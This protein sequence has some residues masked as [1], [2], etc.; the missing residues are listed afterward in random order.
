MGAKGGQEADVTVP[1]EQDSQVVVDAEGPEAGQVTLQ[2]VRPQ[3]WITR[4]CIEPAQGGAQQLTARRAKL[5]SATEETRRSNDPH[6]GRSA[7]DR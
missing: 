3:E 1:A 2:L 6:G 4:V 7:A 5:A